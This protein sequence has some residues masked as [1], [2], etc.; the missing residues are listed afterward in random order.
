[1]EYPGGIDPVASAA[2]SVTAS[3]GP[4]TINSCIVGDSG[5]VTGDFAEIVVVKVNPG[6]G[7]QPDTPGTGTIVAVSCR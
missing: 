4:R 2:H 1:M 6:Y 7:P 5:T 3:R